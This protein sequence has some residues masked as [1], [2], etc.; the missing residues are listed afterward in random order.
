MQD[1]S[2]DRYLTGLS[3]I[4]LLQRVDM[5]GTETGVNMYVVI[6]LVLQCSII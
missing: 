6:V 3:L 1:F 2:Q 5:S 4:N